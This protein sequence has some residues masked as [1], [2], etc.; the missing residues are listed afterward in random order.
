MRRREFTRV[1]CAA[2]AVW[3]LVAR[4]QLTERVRRIGVLM[5]FAEDDADTKAR[6]AGF[7][8][9]LERLGWSEGRN[10]RIDY[11]FA[12][13]GAQAPVFAQE[14]LALKPDVI[15]A[16]ST[17]VTAA[18]QR[19]TRTVPIVFAGITADPGSSGFVSS[20]ARPD[21]NLTGVVLFGPTVTGKWLAM[22][23]EIAPRLTRAALVFNPKTA[24]LL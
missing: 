6:L 5:S 20:M 8:H 11:R 3:P 14:L 9:E 10:L 22:L 13:A 7:R 16:V 12:P 2:V 21:G 23:K 17:P 15:L 19:E 4:A 24:P 1:V 18:L